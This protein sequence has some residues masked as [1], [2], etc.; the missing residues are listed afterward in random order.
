M[1]P[2]S[3]SLATSKTA[4]VNAIIAVCVCFFPQA[5]DWISHNAALTVT[6]I[7]L[8]NIL[9]RT[10]TH[11][12][13]HL[14]AEDEGGLKLPVIVAFLAFFSTAMSCQP[15]L[16]RIDGPRLLVPARSVESPNAEATPDGTIVNPSA[17]RKTSDADLVRALETLT[18]VK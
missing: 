8:F 11:Q 16:L 10:I 12:R 3:K 2:E 5:A 9:L 1:K 4:L 6:G 7:S 18:P 17:Y 15:A 13:I 14:F